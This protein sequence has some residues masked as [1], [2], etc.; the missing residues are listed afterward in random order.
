MSC[1][2]VLAKSRSAISAQIITIMLFDSHPKKRRNKIG[3]EEEKKAPI[4]MNSME[5]SIILIRELE[6]MLAMNWF[7]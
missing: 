5:R 1:Q 3:I 4:Q 2:S 7:E 6:S